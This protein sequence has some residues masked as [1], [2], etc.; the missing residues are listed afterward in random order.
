MKL[1][2][3]EILINKDFKI[4]GQDNR[5]VTV[6]ITVSARNLGINAFHSD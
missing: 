4:I 5:N 6:A 1:T 2:G 3:P